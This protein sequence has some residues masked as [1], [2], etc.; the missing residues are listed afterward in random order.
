MRSKGASSDKSPPISIGVRNLRPS[1][2]SPPQPIATI[3]PAP[4]HQPLPCSLVNDG[5]PARSDNFVRH[6]SSSSLPAIGRSRRQPVRLLGRSP[7]PD[8]SPSHVPPIS[9]RPP[10]HDDRRGHERTLGTCSS[11]RREP[12]ADGRLLLR[13]G[14][15]AS[16]H[17]PHAQAPPK[18]SRTRGWFG[19]GR[20]RGR[21]RVRGGSLRR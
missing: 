11:R 8:D 6:R 19:R 14:L 3:P 5:A 18:I 4:L 15:V 12:R 13:L 1:T 7:P 16:G 10:A 21:R 2:P 9:P 20:G 17:Q